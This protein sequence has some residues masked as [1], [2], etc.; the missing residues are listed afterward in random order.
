MV[1]W[2]LREQCALLPRYQLQRLI[3]C[4]A[5][6]G[7]HA[8]PARGHLQAPPSLRHSQLHDHLHHGGRSTERIRPK[9]TCGPGPSDHTSTYA[10]HCETTGQDLRSVGSNCV[11]QLCWPTHCLFNLTRKGIRTQCNPRTQLSNVVRELQDLFLSRSLSLAEVWK[12]HRRQP[13]VSTR[14]DISSI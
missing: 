4:Q 12:R 5:V 1:R 10:S 3:A 9:H 11:R 13:L 14:E 2:G 6:T 8:S 7:S